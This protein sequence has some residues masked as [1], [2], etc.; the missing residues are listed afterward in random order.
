VDKAT[1][2]V[3]DEDTTVA[4]AKNLATTLSEIDRLISDVVVEKDVATM[5]SDKGKRI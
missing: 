5:P 4:E 2:P 1:I 3:N